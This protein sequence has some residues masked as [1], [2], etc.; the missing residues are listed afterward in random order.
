MVLYI[1][2]CILLYENDSWVI[3]ITFTLLMCNKIKTTTKLCGNNNNKKY[4]YFAIS[5]RSRAKK[6]LKSREARA[7]IK[8]N[9]DV[10]Y[11]FCILGFCS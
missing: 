11:L 5:K 10:S 2:T 3:I 4:I 8:L 1:F 7:V 9:H 6:N